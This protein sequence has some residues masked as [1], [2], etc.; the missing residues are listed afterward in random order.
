MKYK[1]QLTVAALVFALST[2]CLLPTSA[3]TQEQCYHYSYSS[4]Y[5][6][7]H[8]SL[9][10][11]NSIL[12]GNDISII[13]NCQYTFNSE[14]TAPFTTQQNDTV[15]L[16]LDTT[17]ISIKINNNTYLYENLT[18]YPASNFNY[19]PITISDKPTTTTEDLFTSE[20]LA[21]IVTFAILFLMST[22]V[23]YH[24]ASRKIDNTI[25]VII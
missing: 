24:L 1:I 5:E 9:I 6:G 12:I 23:V 16:P 15:Q 10:K 17:W 3:A 25:E 21:H 14:Y 13:S 2:I 19:K 4:D 8:Y 11:N 7:N 22:N 18:I 20:L